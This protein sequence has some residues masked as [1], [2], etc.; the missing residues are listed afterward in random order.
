MPKAALVYWFLTLSVF[1]RFIAIFF[2]FEKMEF[3]GRK[4]KFNPAA[5]LRESI[6]NT[7]AN[8]RGF[9]TNSRRVLVIS[10][11]PSSREFQ[12]MVKATA[13]GIVVIAVVGYTIYLIFTLFGIGKGA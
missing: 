1:K 13:I 2:G 12:A 8:L 10:S 6:S 7:I 9:I 4:E 11:K 5:K 3:E